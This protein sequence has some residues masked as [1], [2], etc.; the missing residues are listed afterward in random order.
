MYESSSLA[1]IPLPGE[2]QLTVGGGTNLVANDIALMWTGDASDPY[3]NA[4]Y[5]TVTSVV[6]T[7]VSVTRGLWGTPIR[8]FTQTPRIAAL[9]Q[10]ISGPQPL[11]NMAK[12]APVNPANGMRAFGWMGKLMVDDFAPSPGAMTL[13]GQE[14]DMVNWWVKPNELTTGR[15]LDCNGDGLPVD[16]RIGQGTSKEDNI[17]GL[18]WSSFF[19]K[20]GAGLAQYDTVLNRPLKVV[21]A[22][23]TQR[24]TAVTNGAEMESFPSWDGYEKSSAA[25]AD[26]GFW[27][28]APSDPGGSFSYAFTKDITPLYGAPNPMNPEGCVTPAEGGT[29]RNGS[30]RYGLAAS[31]MTGAG[32]A[33][34][35]EQGDGSHPVPWDEQGTVNSGVT[36]L[37]TGWLGQPLGGAKRVVRV[38]SDQ[39]DPST[40]SWTSVD[41]TS[42]ASVAS[43][44]HPSG[45]GITT[46]VDISKLTAIP[47]LSDVKIKASL[48]GP[49]TADAEYA[50][51][52]WA[53]TNS[54]MGEGVRDLRIS[55]S[56][57]PGLAPLV[58]ID[59]MWRHFVLQLRPTQDATEATIQFLFGREVGSYQISD[60]RVYEGSEGVLVREFE[61]G[62]AILNDGFTD[63][64]NIALPGGLYKKINGVQDRSVNDGTSVGS[65]LPLIPAKD[66]IVLMR[67]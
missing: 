25:L 63:Q 29:C 66:G 55:L 49:V 39:V 46:R 24:S 2:T 44:Q 12:N 40:W 10:S 59:G 11:Y 35:D 17:Y 4:E 58:K 57:N 15:G 14:F 65:T 16:C 56:G 22:D 31:L 6:G 18:G 54:L 20:V 45:Q 42:A 38:G 1:A 28:S 32:H 26:L 7:T 43:N 64:A 19:S 37:T 50:V 62:I 23:S 21:L 51:D 30:F 60:A 52:F 53:K 48:V 13:D 8:S 27:T 34:L 5:V 9:A 33:Y 41:G 67:A 36:G 3:A 47:D 61:H